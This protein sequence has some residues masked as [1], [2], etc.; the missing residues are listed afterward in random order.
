ML[1]ILVALGVKLLSIGR[2]QRFE[3]SILFFMLSKYG[4]DLLFTFLFPDK[5]NLSGI[6][7]NTLAVCHSALSPASHWMYASQY[8]KTYYLTAGI[9]KK[10]NLL[11]ERNRTVID[12]EYETTSIMS[13]FVYKHFAIDAQLKEEKSKS[14]RIKKIFLLFALPES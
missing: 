4:A 13:S 7:F 10:A 11:L 9:V 8:L 1:L 3:M 6:I 12:N 14:K 5:N 2:Y